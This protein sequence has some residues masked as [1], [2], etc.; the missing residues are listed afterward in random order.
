[1]KGDP[2]TIGYGHLILKEEME[3][4]I[5][6]TTGEAKNIVMVITAKNGVIAVISTNLISTITAIEA[7]IAAEDSVMTQ[8]TIDGIVAVISI[9][10]V[11][12]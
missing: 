3:K 11:I 12:S 8:S 1:M 7:V 6:I 5:K 2:W 10:Q 9:N 4:L